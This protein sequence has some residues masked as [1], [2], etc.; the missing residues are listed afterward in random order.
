MAD[1][2]I[3]LDSVGSSGFTSALNSVNPGETL[4]LRGCDYKVGSF[5]EALVIAKSGIAG[6]PIT[7]KP[8][9][10]ETVIVRQDKNAIPTSYTPAVRVNASYINLEGIKVME[11]NGP[12]IAIYSPNYKEIGG[13]PTKYI[14]DIL[15]KN[16][17]FTN[18]NHIGMH[19]LYVKNLTITGCTITRHLCASARIPAY[20]TAG[21]SDHTGQVSFNKIAGLEFAYNTMGDSYG[22]GLMVEA[23]R[24]SGISSYDIKIHH[25][26]L[27]NGHPD[28]MTVYLHCLSD[29]GY[30][31]YFYNNIV[32]NTPQAYY[33]TDGPAPISR[34]RSPGV[35]MITSEVY[36]KGQVNAPL[37]DW[38]FYNNLIVNTETGVRVIQGKDS[39]SPISN[40]KWYNNT[41]VNNNTAFAPALWDPWVSGSTGNEF[42]NN[43]VYCGANQRWVNTNNVSSADLITFSNN[44]WYGSNT[45][46]PSWASGSGDV[47][48]NPALANPNVSIDYNTIDPVNYIPGGGSPLID[49]GADTGITIDYFGNSRVGAYDI[50]FSEAGGAVNS[51]TPDWNETATSIAKGNTI[52]FSDNTTTTGSAVVTDRLWVFEGGVPTNPVINPA[53]GL[54]N[55]SRDASPVVTYPTPG[56]YDVSYTVYDENYVQAGITKTETDYINVTTEGGDATFVPKIVQFNVGDT[57]ITH[58]M[59]VTPQYAMFVVSGATA[60]DTI[61]DDIRLSV[62]VCDTAP[63]SSHASSVTQ[64]DGTAEADGFRRYRA[65]AVSLYTNTSTTTT[66]KCYATITAVSS[67]TITLSWSGDTSDAEIGYV[68]LGGGAAINSAASFEVTGLTTTGTTAQI[69]GTYDVV[70]ALS[71]LSSG[72]WNPSLSYGWAV[73]DDNQCCVG[74]DEEHTAT[75][76]DPRAYIR[77]DA[78]ACH[79]TMGGYVT[80]AF[81]SSY[82]EFTLTGQ[83]A[84][85]SATA[86]RLHVL[87][88][89]LDGVSAA[90]GVDTLPTSASTNTDYTLSFTPGFGMCAISNMAAVNTQYRDNTA[91]YIGLYATD[92]STKFTASVMTEDA[93]GTINCGTAISANWK[94]YDDDQTEL[95][96]DDGNGLTLGTN[97]FTINTNPANGGKFAWLMVESSGGAVG[98]DAYFEYSFPGELAGRTNPL[99]NELVTFTNLSDQGASAISG[100]YWDFG[101]DSTVITTENAT[102]TYTA[103]GTYTVYLEVTD[104]GGGTD[105]YT[106]TIEVESTTGTDVIWSVDISPTSG[107][108][109]LDVTVDWSETVI[110]NESLD[111]LNPYTYTQLWKWD[112]NFQVGAGGSGT[113]PTITLNDP[114]T[115]SLKIEAV[116]ESWDSYEVEYENVVTAY[117]DANIEL[118]VI[119]DPRTPHYGGTE[120][121]FSID[122]TLDVSVDTVAWDFGDGDTSAAAVPAPVTHTYAAVTTSTKY[123][124]TATVNFS[125]G[126]T[127]TA[128]TTLWIVPERTAPRTEAEFTALAPL[129][130]QAIGTIETTDWTATDYTN[131]I[132]S[133]SATNT[134][135]HAANCR[136]ELMVDTIPSAGEARI[137]F[138]KQDSNNFWRFDI[139]DSGDFDLKEVVGGVTTTRGT[140][141]G[142]ISNGTNVLVIANDETI[143]GYYDGTL[144]WSYNSA[145]NFKT[146]TGGYVNQLGTG[147]VISDLATWPLTPSGNGPVYVAALDRPWTTAEARIAE[148]CQILT[149]K[150]SIYEVFSNAGSYY[151]TKDGDNLTIYVHATNSDDPETNGNIYRFLRPIMSIYVV[152]NVS[153]IETVSILPPPNINASETTTISETV[154]VDGSPNSIAKERT[155]I[156]ETIN[157][158]IS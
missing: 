27:Y 129:V 108:V 128:T 56:L 117:I 81:Y 112:G 68:I 150:D 34:W 49:A 12:S 31:N 105:T 2:I 98:L 77:D 135:T 6:K 85:G 69:A 33:Y 64:N 144:A 51:L 73:R 42:K 141:S 59:G 37:T 139:E 78:M 55:A 96:D 21:L 41:F 46:L 10:N 25:N 148:D 74:F 118:T 101:D 143:A 126:Y 116:T 113:S 19:C 8:Y 137:E 127:Q 39:T 79:G 32:Y 120:F 115:Y 97:K 122:T 155:S 5:S 91:G 130:A 92:G 50:G 29:Y 114:G 142:V 109:P 104:A 131:Y 110:P 133:P 4:Y 138:R 53:T 95:A 3:D 86:S 45:V 83:L 62:S 18:G 124:V 47:T 26:K 156:S 90:C 154:G 123:T 147:G 71:S 70:I 14:T 76:G 48:A 58:S 145:S 103:V 111:N 94:Q 100:Y 146:A 102:H 15:I 121:T 63:I 28:D 72:A 44:S 23:F 157:I 11:S 24:T 67:T 125:A 30:V 43:V 75:A 152:E 36:N 35:E 119:P 65:G 136:I 1:Q 151:C 87:A 9:N 134:F 20:K 38:M 54:T 40:N 88:F 84:P 132:A 16:C 149:E 7:I 52:T 17:T 89:D 66:E 158:V 60:V 99:V 153:I 106:T 140:E 107:P 13:D 93:A 22:E 82:V 57:T 61:L 80:A